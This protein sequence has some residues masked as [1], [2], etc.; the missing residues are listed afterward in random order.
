MIISLD[1]WVAAVPIPRNQYSPICFVAAFP[2]DISYNP[3]KRK[4]VAL[5]RTACSAVLS[6]LN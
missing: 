5:N 4:K 6:T 1:Q 2:H 3:Y